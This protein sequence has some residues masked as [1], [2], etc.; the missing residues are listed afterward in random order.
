MDAIFY[1]TYKELC[2]KSLRFGEFQVDFR[3]FQSKFLNDV[4]GFI[5]FTAKSV[6]CAHRIVCTFTD[7][8]HFLR[9]AEGVV[10]LFVDQGNNVFVNH[11][12]ITSC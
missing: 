3:M 11:F 12:F 7:V 10:V 2:K 9:H 6:H 8:I 1:R 5:E 4:S